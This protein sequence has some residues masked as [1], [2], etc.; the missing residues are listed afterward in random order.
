MNA[1]VYT[2]I[3]TDP[4]EIFATLLQMGGDIPRTAAALLMDPVE[5]KA[6]DNKFNWQAKIKT[7]GA[8]ADS[9]A[10]EQRTINRAV[11]F[12]L[13]HRLRKVI[14]GIVTDLASSPDKIA[15]FTTVVTKNGLQRDIKPLRELAD[16]ARIATEMTYRA[17]GDSMDVTLSDTKADPKKTASELHM[18]VLKAMDLV[19]G[20]PSIGSVELIKQQ[21]SQRERIAAASTE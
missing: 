7:Y 18:S 13:S 12:L 15:A 21:V 19:D 2:P 6:L 11:N 20:S 10:K 8:G 1:V 4:A 9:S 3:T 17:L 16:S 5:L 14:D